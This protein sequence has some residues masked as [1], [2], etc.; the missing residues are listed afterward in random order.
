M[1]FPLRRRSGIDKGR[2]GI[3]EQ[4]EQLQA[5]FRRHNKSA[6]GSKEIL[7]LQ[8]FDDFGPRRRCANALCLL[9]A[10][11]HRFVLN[12]PP[13]ILH[14]I[15][16][17]AFIILRRRHCPLALDFRLA[18]HRVLTVGQRRQRLFRLLLAGFGFAAAIDRLPAFD[19]RNTAS[20][21][22]LCFLSAW[23]GHLHGHDR[24]AIFEIRHHRSEVGPAD[25][26]EQPL[27]VI[28]EVRETPLQAIHDIDIRHDGVVRNA[29]QCLVAEM[30]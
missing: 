15:D 20:C 10:V 23:H 30:S 1:H 21:T 29:R 16:Q 5:G 28:A 9:Q 3:P 27:F 26:R 11:T 13:G 12:E 4:P 17:R 8:P 22:K 7:P 19:Q 24:L 18:Q 6:I 25:Q 2:R 14:R